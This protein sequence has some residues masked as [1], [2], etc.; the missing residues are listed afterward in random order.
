MMLN[1]SNGWGN[2]LKLTLKQVYK[3]L[4]NKWL[5][6]KRE[7]YFGELRKLITPETSIISSNCFAGR[8]M[9]DLGMKYNSPTLGLYFWAEDYNEFLLHLD[10]YLVAPY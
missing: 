10:Y 9:Q 7:P 2:S 6:K 3:W 1:N 4:Q 5:K 8:I